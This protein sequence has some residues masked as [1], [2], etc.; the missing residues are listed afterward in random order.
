VE[1]VQQRR[2]ELEADLE[3]EVGEVSGRYDPE[4]VVLESLAIRPRKNDISVERLVLTWAPWW[5]HPNGSSRPA[6]E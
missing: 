6:F 2:A 4:P 5:V 1:Q 3:R